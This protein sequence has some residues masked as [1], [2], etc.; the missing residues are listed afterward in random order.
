MAAM[1][2]EMVG[3]LCICVHSAAPPS[4]AEWDH[5]LDEIRPIPLARLKILAIT[6]GGGPDSIQRGQFIDYLA[7]SHPRVAVVSDSIAVRGI[8]TALSW[9]TSNLKVFSPS[10]FHQAFAYLDLK[11]VSDTAVRERVRAAAGKLTGPELKAAS[12][13]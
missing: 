1:I 6:D 7:G 3:D 13:L 2:V 5:M 4:R 12:G 8:A 10:A 11:G 9:F